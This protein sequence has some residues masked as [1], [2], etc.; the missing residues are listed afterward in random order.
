MPNPGPHSPGHTDPHRPPRCHYLDSSVPV[1]LSCVTQQPQN[2]QI[3]DTADKT[4]P[5]GL[6]ACTPP[7]LL[8]SFTMLPLVSDSRFL[9]LLLRACFSLR[10]GWFVEVRGKAKRACRLPDDIK[11]ICCA[12]R[13]QRQRHGVMKRLNQVKGS[14]KERKEQKH[15]K[16]QKACMTV[17][18]ATW[19]TRS[20]LPIPFL[21]PLALYISQELGVA[22]CRK[23]DV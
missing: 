21:C 11:Q 16:R 2:L 12:S 23:V 3:R 15:E 14:K 13:E 9:S 22:V 4:E 10:E 20:A 17:E 19:V 8:S 1:P 5:C 18:F 6:V 7:E